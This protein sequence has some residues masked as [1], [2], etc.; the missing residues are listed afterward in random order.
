MK[1]L[2]KSLKKKYKF[3]EMLSLMSQNYIKC[4]DELKHRTTSSRINT[5]INK[6]KHKYSLK[7]FDYEDTD[8][9]AVSRAFVIGLC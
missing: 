6:L 5:A 2:M 8:N 4:H 7:E 9:I 3:N 1:A